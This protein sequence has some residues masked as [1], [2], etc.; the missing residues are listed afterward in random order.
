[1]ATWDVQYRDVDLSRLTDFLETRGLR[2]AGRATGTNR[3]A[4]PLGEWAM[5]RGGGVVGHRA[6]A[7]RRDDD[8][9]RCPRPASQEELRQRPGGRTVQRAALA[10]LRADRRPARLPARPAVDHARSELGR[11]AEDLRRVPGRDGLRPALEHPVSRHQPRLAGKRPRARG[12][13]D[14]VRVADRRDS[15]RRPRRV[16]RRDA[17]G[18]L[19]AAHRRQ[20]SP[21]TGMRAWNVVWGKGR[22]DVVIENSYAERQE[23]GHHRRC[24]GDHGRRPVLARLSTQGRRRADQRARQDDPP[25]D[26]RPEARVRARRLRHGRP[27][28]GRVPR[29]RQLRDAARLRPA[30]DRGRRGLRRDLRLDDVGAAVRGHRRAARH[31]SDR[32]EHRRGHRRGVGRL[33]RD[34]FV[35]RRRPRASRSSR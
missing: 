24:L 8:A 6:S 9:R 35:Q 34:L 1:M 32:Q 31:H 15:D 25:A 5:K 16:R 11:D 28:L 3:L 13:H 17:R 18:V 12:D 22:A 29:L 7:R 4:W 30:V 19:A 21:A 20:C 27:G 10:R 14:D 23:R 33:G 26:G 2:L